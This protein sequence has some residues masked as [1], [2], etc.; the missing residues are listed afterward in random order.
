MVFNLTLHFESSGVSVT[1]FQEAQAQTGCWNPNSGQGGGFFS[2]LGT[3]ISNIGT[4]IANVA[5]AIGNFFSGG[6]EG[7]EE[8]GDETGSNTWFEPSGPPDNFY[9]PMD[10]PWF[11]PPGFGQ[12]EWDIMNNLGYWY[13]VY[14]GG[15][16]SATQDC[17]GVWGGSA[18]TG[19]CGICIGG[20]T[21]LTACYADSPR[22]DTV[23]AIKIPCDSAANARG[24]KLTRIRDSINSNADV[25]RVKD[26]ALR[27]ANEAGVSITNNGG[28][29]SS[30]N[31]KTGA[32]NNVEVLQ[33]SPG[34]NIVAGIHS[35][36]QGGGDTAA[37]SPSPADLYHL[38]EGYQ[39]NNNYIAD[40]IFSHDSTEWALMISDPSVIDTFL[41]HHP[42]DSTLMGA[43]WDTT[44]IN[45]TT[46]SR[47]IDHYTMMMA[48]LYQTQ[49]YPL[50]MIQGY[51]NTVM[52]TQILTPG[53]RMY[54]RVNG[55]FK[56][57]NVQITRDG[58]G[59]PTALSITICQ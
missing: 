53:V 26:S 12:D 29:Y 59:T 58:T 36:G 47:I 46:G 30:F 25:L 33:S 23:K 9:N 22:T 18:Y 55:Q 35:H 5:S 41:T 21:G 56:E 7:G 45:P 37:N 40:F 43:D 28:T 20:S 6:G 38:L 57:L 39:S 31:F 27:S 11:N 14:S 10:D 34:Q 54:R 32:H 4:A 3:A 52:Y 50:E 1:S 49:H 24:A 13:G 8:F 48:Y 16:S 17:N 51:A 44:A 42:A 19:S 15:G 2:W